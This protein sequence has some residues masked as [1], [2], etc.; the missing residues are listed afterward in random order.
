MMSVKALAG[1]HD[2]E[3]VFR[4]DLEKLENLIKHLPVLGSHADLVVEVL[5]VP[6]QFFHH[7]RH[8]D[9]FRPGAEHRE[10]FFLHDSG[11]VLLAQGPG[12]SIKPFLHLKHQA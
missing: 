8:L 5:R 4:P 6:G 9:G 11:W 2:V 7:R 12:D 10:D 1:L 3:V